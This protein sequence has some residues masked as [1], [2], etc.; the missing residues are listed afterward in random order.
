VI[1]ATN[2]FFEITRTGQGV[3]LL[4]FEPDTTFKCLNELLYLLIKPAL[5]TFFRDDWKTEE[6]IHFVVDNGPAEQQ[7]SPLVQ[8]SLVRLLKLLTQVS[9]AEYHSKRNFVERV[10]SQEN[11]VLS[12]ASKFNSH[13]VYEKAKIG[14]KEHRENMESALEEMRKRKRLLHASFGGRPLMSE[15]AE[16]VRSRGGRLHRHRGA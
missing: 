16:D 13:S 15:M 12:K 3:T 9:F 2:S 4:N 14:S 1:P 5:D 6:A 8:M 11:N 10:H 7:S